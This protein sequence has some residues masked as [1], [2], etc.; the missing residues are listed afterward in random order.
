MLKRLKAAWSYSKFYPYC[1]EADEAWTDEDA[2]ATKGFFS[3]VTGQRLALRLRNTVIRASMQA[4]CDKYSEHAA[5][6]AA[7]MAMAIATLEQH[8]PQTEP[9][10]TE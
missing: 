4:C 3:S 5:G 2:S 7:G 1:P 10:P 6:K 8:Y 9:E